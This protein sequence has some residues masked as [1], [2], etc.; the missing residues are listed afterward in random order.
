MKRFIA[1]VF[2]FYYPFPNRDGNLCGIVLQ[3][4]VRK[5]ASVDSKS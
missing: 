2:K 4:G 5:S 1:T 3:E